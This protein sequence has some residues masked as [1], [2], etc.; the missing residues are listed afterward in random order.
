MN[1]NVI[2]DDI[3]STGKASRRDR[4]DWRA[5]YD[6]PRAKRPTAKRQGTR[7]AAIA[8]HLREIGATR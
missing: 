6:A 2:A 4:R 1:R 7:Q 3:H 8:T 5:E